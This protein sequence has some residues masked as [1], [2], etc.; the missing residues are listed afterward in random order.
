VFVGGTGVGV[1]VSEGSPERLGRLKGRN[2]GVGVGVFVFVS[3]AH[4]QAGEFAGGR[5]RVGG[6]PVKGRDRGSP[7]ERATDQSAL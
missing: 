2:V 4:R 5:G 6:A 1:G 7:V 3:E